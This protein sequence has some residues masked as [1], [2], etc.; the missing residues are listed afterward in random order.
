MK[1]IL[2]TLFF[3]LLLLPP[4]LLANTYYVDSEG[5]DSDCD[6]TG[7]GSY[8][9][10]CNSIADLLALNPASGS[11]TIYFGAGDTFSDA[12]IDIPA[13]WTNAYTTLTFE[14]ES[15]TNRPEIGNG[16][17][18]PFD[19]DFYDGS[20]AGSLTTLYVKN[21]NMTGQDWDATNQHFMRIK[22]ITNAYIDNVHIDGEG[23]GG[24][25]VNAKEG[26]WFEAV[27][28]IIEVTD[29]SIKRLCDATCNQTQDVYSIYFDQCNG[30]SRTIDNFTCDDVEAD[31]IQSRR[32]SSYM[33]IKN[34]DFNNCAEECIDIKGDDLSGG[35]AGIIET[36]TFSEDVGFTAAYQGDDFIQ[37]LACGTTD[38]CSGAEQHSNNWIVQDCEFNGLRGVGTD[39]DSRG[40]VINSARTGP[41]WTKN[42][43]LRRNKF[44][45]HE[46]AD[47][48][49]NN[50]YEGLLIEN[51]VLLPSNAANT[52]GKIVINGDNEDVTDNDT[53]ITN[54]SIYD[55]NDSYGIRINDASGDYTR[56]ANNA[57][58]Y[59]NAAGYPLYHADI[60][61]PAG[62]AEYNHLWNPSGTDAFW[63]NTSYTATAAWTG[64]G[65]TDG[66]IED[67]QFNNPGSDELFINEGGNLIDRG[68]G[69]YLSTTGLRYDSTWVDGVIVINAVGTRDRGAYEYFEPGNVIGVTFE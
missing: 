15:T 23:A 50:G 10:G 32:S 49:L 44:K 21:I 56:I 66:E 43:I 55:T 54:N 60:T 20:P 61:S 22:L 51:N 25:D 2:T 48:Y 11:H 42:V 35:S 67:P 36:S 47:I 16:A 62:T 6:N 64:A 38:G 14:G 69:S 57:I 45:D 63:D 40:I 7:G 13:N 1:K 18:K 5:D 12:T 46:G 9:T 52:E 65:H 4:S 30:G 37:F 68:G 27:N 17:V 53:E 39:A 29:S 24:G 41:V 33:I 34:S 3:I 58:H 28:G 59:D 31:C 26:I 19:F 8:A